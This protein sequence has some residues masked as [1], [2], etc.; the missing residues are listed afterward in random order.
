M[1]VKTLTDYEIALIELNMMIHGCNDGHDLNT[2]RIIEKIIKEKKEELD[3]KYV[4][5]K[6]EECM[7]Q[8]ICGV[9]KQFR[10]A[11]TECPAANGPFKIE[12]RCVFFR[13]EQP[14]RKGEISYV[15]NN[16]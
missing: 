9:E 5:T 12:L 4:A 3:M 2:L 14:T 10:E 1:A 8:C 16:G 13:K 7:H 15:K 6:C 11:F